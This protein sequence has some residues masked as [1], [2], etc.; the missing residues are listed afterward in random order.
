MVKSVLE[1]SLLRRGLAFYIDGLIITALALVYLFVFD[2]RGPTISCD[3]FICWNTD[4][5]IIFQLV[6]YYVYFFLLEYFFQNTL[7]KKVLGFKVSRKKNI[8][9]FWRIFM[10]TFIRLVPLN[11]I[12]FLFNHDQ[13]FLHEKWTRIHTYRDGE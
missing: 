9:L 6:F 13:L 2:K 12:S 1:N 3:N 8:M 4:R 5:V 11:L 7:G 10:R